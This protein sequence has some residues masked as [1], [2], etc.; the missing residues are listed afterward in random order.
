MR[1]EHELTQRRDPFT[2]STM[3]TT[4]EKLSYLGKISTEH[5]ILALDHSKGSGH[6]LPKHLASDV[7]EPDR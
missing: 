2:L 4:T 7:K 1:A 5:Y 3:L 6:S